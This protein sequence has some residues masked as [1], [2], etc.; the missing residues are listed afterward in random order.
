MSCYGLNGNIYY[1]SLCK[2]V[3]VAD[4]HHFVIILECEDC[5]YVR[6]LNSESAILIWLKDC[7]TN[8]ASIILPLLLLMRIIFWNSR[9]S[10]FYHRSLLNSYYKNVQLVSQANKYTCIFLVLLTSHL[11]YLF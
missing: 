4:N 1:I 3:R 6:L 10:D 11:K 8:S 7:S 5:D 2:W 9:A